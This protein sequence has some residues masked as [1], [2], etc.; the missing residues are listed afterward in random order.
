M[1]LPPDSRLGPYAIVAPLG[2]GGM[3]EVYRARDTRLG[4][5]VA[6]KVLPSELSSAKDRLRCFEEEARAA[7][8]ALNHPNIVLRIQRRGVGPVSRY[9]AP[10]PWAARGGSGGGRARRGF[11]HGF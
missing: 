9:A 11:G 10:Q 7:S 4:R 3:G 5:Q 6:I 8:S 1:T 2:S